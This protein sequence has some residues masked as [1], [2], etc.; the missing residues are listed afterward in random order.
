MPQ[1]DN[2][3]LVMENTRKVKEDA[4]EGG[5]IMGRTGR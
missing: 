3:D 2:Y 5:V 1:R 4:S